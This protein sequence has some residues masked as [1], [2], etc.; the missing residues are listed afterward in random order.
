[1]KDLINNLIKDFLKI[2]ILKNQ[3]M[4]NEKRENFVYLGMDF[5]K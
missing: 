3:N 4:K 2:L 1:M 5:T